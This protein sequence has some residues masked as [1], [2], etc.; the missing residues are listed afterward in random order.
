MSSF[1][2]RVMN[3]KIIN[4]LNFFFF[5]YILSSEEFATETSKSYLAEKY[6]IILLPNGRHL[7]IL[8]CRERPN[9]SQK[10]HRV[11]YLFQTVC[12]LLPL[13]CVCS[14]YETC[15]PWQ[16]DLL[17]HTPV[18]SPEVQRIAFNLAIYNPIL[19]ILQ[20]EYNINNIQVIKIMICSSTYF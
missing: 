11:G 14:V 20:I 18:A 7:P 3:C 2:V 16:S 19:Q 6:I 17:S 5:F 13:R 9:S 12:S 15:L 10:C 8:F 4:L 1:N